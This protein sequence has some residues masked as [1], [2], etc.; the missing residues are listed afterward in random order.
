[1][2][3][4]PRGMF[5]TRAYP[6]PPYRRLKRQLDSSRSPR[7]PHPGSP[8]MPDAWGVRSPIWS[9]EAQ[10]QG[11]GESH[12]SLLSRAQQVDRPGRLMQ[13]KASLAGRP[14]GLLLLYSF[15]V[16]S[17]YVPRLW[18]VWRPS[19]AEDGTPMSRTLHLRTNG[20]AIRTAGSP[21]SQFHPRQ[22]RSLAASLIDSQGGW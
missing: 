11:E 4:A 13:G 1:M 6:R 3:R 12:S 18:T 16:V 9:T 22:L 7:R 2:V 15:E 21:A 17:S 20:H 14:L 19:T 10:L 5:G 8:S